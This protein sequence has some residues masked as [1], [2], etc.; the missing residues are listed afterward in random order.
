MWRGRSGVSQRKMIRALILLCMVVISVARCHKVIIN[1]SFTHSL[2]C[3]NYFFFP[4]QC[5]TGCL[6]IIYGRIS[7][8]LFVLFILFECDNIIK[9]K[10]S[11]RE[12]AIFSDKTLRS[13][14][15]LLSIMRIK[16]L[17]SI[18]I[19]EE[20][21]KNLFNLFFYYH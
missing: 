13:H 16:I 20:K 18:I 7:L 4:F 10:S 15:E 6:L 9:C 5:L 14:L 12:S 3:N 17:L 1:Y 8:S 11:A 21:E 2:K 19:K